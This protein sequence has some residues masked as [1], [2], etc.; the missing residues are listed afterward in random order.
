MVVS[1]A[2]PCYHNSMMTQHCQDTLT[3]E[4]LIARGKA[5]TVTRTGNYLRVSTD[6]DTLQALQRN[7]MQQ[8]LGKKLQEIREAGGVSAAALA[9]ELNIDP[10]VLSHW[11]AGR[12]KIPEEMIGK[13]VAKVQEIALRRA[14]AV[15]AI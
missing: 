6:P 4:D 3:I 1:P 7:G 8:V 11:E 13:Y 15:G 12:R 10:T 14:K 9:R 2:S 5:A